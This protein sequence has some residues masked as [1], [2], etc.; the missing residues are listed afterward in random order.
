[1][2]LYW[3][4]LLLLAI[5]LTGALLWRELAADPGYLLLTFRGWAVESTLVVALGL[6]LVAWL[7]LVG[8]FAL[9]RAPWRL[10]HRRRRQQSRE[11]LAGGLLALQEGRWAKAEKLLQRAANDPGQRLAAL[12]AA[13]QAAQARGDDLQA[14]KLLSRA[15]QA[16]GEP[17][18]LIS[19]ANRLLQRGQAASTVEMLEAARRRG[20]LPPLAL[21]L[22]ARA[23]SRNGRAVEALPLLAEI[24]RSQLRS[25][26]VL[27]E[28]ECELAAASLV[29]ADSFGELRQRL[30][31]LER[32]WRQRPAVVAAF[33]RR[34]ADFGEIA[35]A[36]DA[37]EGALAK[38]WSEPLVAL[39]GRLAH[40]QPRRALK[41]AEAWLEAQPDN[42][43]ALL[44]L[45]RLCRGEQLWGKAEEFLLKALD[46]GAGAAG[47]EALGELYA[48]QGDDG[49]ARQALANALAVQRGESIKPVQR[50]ERTPRALAALEERDHMGLPRLPTG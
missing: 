39:Y 43:T 44:A 49:R 38:R 1:V 45:G 5:G 28:L 21:E 12:L 50:L 13:A 32:E 11:R 48:A 6:F 20:V 7:L 34:A 24:R 18:V 46:R 31:Q 35:A 30:G 27:H 25:G 33:A 9:L 3:R 26:G 37:L 16:D 23:L 42:A 29:Q 36:A 14:E 19:C 2:R 8:L 17:A 4:L 15:A 22:Y 47:W 10:W 40:P 41:R